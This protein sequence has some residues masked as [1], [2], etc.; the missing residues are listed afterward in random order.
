VA[1]MFARIARRYD[2]LNT[3]MTGGAHHRWRHDAVKMARPVEGLALDVATGTGDFAFDLARSSSEAHVVGL[4]VVPEMLTLA[5]L[6]ALRRRMSQRVTWVHGDAQ[7]LPFADDMFQVITS[8][9][10]LR[11]VSDLPRT[12]SEMCR[13][14]T[15]GGRVALLEITPVQ[16]PR[17]F[18][19][20]FRSY[21][22]HVTP[23]LGALLAGDREAYAYLPSSVEQFPPADA[24][25]ELMR[26]A[27]FQDVSY[28]LR[29]MGTV[30]IHTGTKPS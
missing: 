29:G 19:A 14:A 1:R 9:F 4:D 3:V 6:K 28:K 25:A 11:N 16:G 12:L 30:A 26:A 22:R 18:Q 20:F 21:F 5:N 7:A 24:L 15:P 2:F 13:V 17:L 10:A 27:G 23:R 8:G